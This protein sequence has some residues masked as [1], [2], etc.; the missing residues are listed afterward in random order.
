VLAWLM[1][2]SGTLLHR[3]GWFGRDVDSL[4][5]AFSEGGIDYPIA[6]ILETDYQKAWRFNRHTTHTFNIVEFPELAS[7]TRHLW[8][9]FGPAKYT[10]L[11]RAVRAQT[12]GGDQTSAV[13]P[14]VYGVS[15]D[16]AERQWR[17]ELKRLAATKRD[18]TIDVTRLARLVQLFVAVN[19]ISARSITFEDAN[20]G[21]FSKKYAPLIPAMPLVHL[22]LDEAEKNLTKAREELLADLTLAAA[23]V[24]KGFGVKL[25]LP[26]DASTQPAT[27]RPGACIVARVLPGGLGAKHGLKKGDEVHLLDNELYDQAVKG[28]PYSSVLRVTREGEP[29]AVVLTP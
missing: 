25:E 7:F 3:G 20:A 9:T 29:K 1:E 27:L 16:D 6:T 23:A 11:L 12:S 22:E 24:E 26:F 18:S 4:A 15:L 2:G 21:T 17:A 19:E 13:F 28:Q 14:G 5:I 8:Q 10:A